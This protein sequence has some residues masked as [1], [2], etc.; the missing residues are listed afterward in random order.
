[1]QKILVKSFRH[2]DTTE[3]ID[4]FLE[5]KIEAKFQDFSNFDDDA[6]NFTSCILKIDFEDEEQFR[7]ARK[8]IEKNKHIK[9]LAYLENMNKVT[10]NLAYQS[11][12]HKFCYDLESLKN[13]I[14]GDSLPRKA[15]KKSAFSKFKGAKILLVDDIQIN[16]DVLKDILSPF[17]FEIHSYTSAKSALDKTNTTKFDLIFLDISMPEINGFDFAAKIKKSKLNAA[18]GVVFVTGND[19]IQSAIRGYSLGS[20]AYIKKPLD[21]ETLRAQ[22][23]GILET[24]ALQ[25]EIIEEK[26]N[27]IQMLTHDLK[28]PINA[29]LGAV[30]LL[31]NGCFGSVN[32][33]QKEI[34]TEILAS[35]N[36]MLTMVRNV[37]AKYKY[38]NIAIE[39]VKS[40]RKIN[41]DIMEIINNFRFMLDKKGL[42]ISVGGDLDIVIDYDEV[43][44]RRVLNNL[45]S[46]AI[47]HCAENTIIEI[48]VRKD[49]NYLRVSVAN[50]GCGIPD[51]DLSIIFDKYTTKA[52]K[53]RKVGF[54]LGL[55]ICKEIIEA[56]GGK[57][58]A[59][60]EKSKDSNENG[61]IITFEFSL[62]ITP[63]TDE[64]ESDDKEV[65]ETKVLK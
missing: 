42:N 23:Y 11:G 8:F 2:S 7:M 44:L 46:N 25:N 17:C 51:E 41:N 32:D 26:E 29:Q 9:F 38:R 58:G 24:K 6:E 21:I 36:Y 65:K 45:I 12:C 10:L 30:K 43:E 15:Y 57:I 18:T 14:I 19:E 48:V 16:L 4:F 13:L 3:L 39:L 60:I 47:E 31:L 34:L 33:K 27:F 59:R 63:L 52:R 22:V 56:H 61:R 1:M 20:V 62:P 50:R 54:G 55:Y 35:N 64:P 5:N 40:K 49:R 37:L 28:T 53:Y